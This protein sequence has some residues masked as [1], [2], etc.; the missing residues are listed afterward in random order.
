MA[1]VPV[2]EVIP[3]E[4]VQPEVIRDDLVIEDV[5]N[6]QQNELDED[7]AK[8]EVDDDSVTVPDQTMKTSN[9]THTRELP[10][11]NNIIK[12]RQQDSDEWKTALVLGRGGRATGQYQ[13]CLN[14]RNLENN[15]EDCLDWKRDVCEWKKVGVNALLTSN[16]TIGYEEAMETELEKWKE[17]KVYNEVADEGQ[18]TVSVR[19]VP[20][21]KEVNNVKVKKARLVARGFEEFNVDLPTDSPTCNK[22]SL[23]TVISVISS[24]GWDI[25][26]LDVKAAFLQGKEID[27]DVYLK[28]PKEAKCP[29]ILW[30]LNRCVYG[31]DDASRVWYFRMK[32]ELNKL[33]CKN[34]KLDP[35]L[36]IYYNEG[37]EGLLISHV[38]DFLWAGTEKFEQS[39]ISKL[40]ETFKI[41]SENSNAFKYIGIELEQGRNGIYYSQVTYLD[42]LQ[43]IAIEP[44]RLA[45]KES[46][47]NEEER[48]KLRSAIGK[49]NWLATQTRPDLSYD[50]CEL[51]TN[52]KSATVELLMKANKVIKKAK[53]NKVFLHYPVLDLNNLYVRCYTDASW[54]NLPDGGS[55]GGV[56]V[57]VTDGQLS[58]PVEW[59]SKRLRR[60]PKSTLAAET[61]AMVEGVECGYLAS[62]LISEIVYNNT[63]SIPVEV[64][65]DNMSLYEA[66]HSTTSI[67]DR[68][69]RVELA[70]LRE[71]ISKD[72]IHMKW[73]RS[74]LQLADCFTKKGSDPRKLIA[75]ITGKAVY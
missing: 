49:L 58:A 71:C 67:Q 14:I 7:S 50:V 44:D 42:K 54:K 69:L 5:N 17:L 66:A 6:V 60:V 1:E 72:E 41:S 37:L 53:M 15:E 20:T 47:V 13:Y 11:K 23:R 40:K 22:E 65:T 4:E 35:A 52:Q 32:E 73:V 70:I 25:N 61:I 36:F 46:P 24:K 51:S 74:E 38:D 39:V 30:K 8:D 9:M 56:Y 48:E 59:Q 27:R 26:S 12:F 2:Q 3:P 63:K 10:K 19:W 75:H 31:L 33:E 29:G 43:E 55:Q 68:R 64:V 62:K 18:D 57:E 34:S 45:N 21:E 16:S 28:P